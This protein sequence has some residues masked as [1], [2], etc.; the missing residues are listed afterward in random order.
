MKSSFLTNIA[1]ILI[2][3]SV[4]YFILKSRIHKPKF[5]VYNTD[6]LKLEDII[7]WFKK[8][9]SALSD[10][11]NL[12]AVLL[13]LDNNS[14]DSIRDSL[15]EYIDTME[16]SFKFIQAIRDS[17]SGKILIMR[18]IRTKAVE[19][20]ITEQFGEKSILNFK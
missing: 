4:S 14:L 13:K 9:L 1:V 15:K 3:I 17:S 7:E 6:K 2:I 19:D 5:E 18:I 8:R 20:V 12:E 16:Y 11:E 10:Q